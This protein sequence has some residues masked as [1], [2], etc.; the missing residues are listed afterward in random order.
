MFIVVVISTIAVTADVVVMLLP[1]LPLVAVV[2]R[3]MVRRVLL[4]PAIV[5]TRALREWM[6]LLLV[7]MVML[8]LVVVA[9]V[10]MIA[11]AAVIVKVTVVHLPERIRLS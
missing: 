2:K 9:N 6:F 1:F 11:S 8:I 7:M 5:V 4:A 3:V 10:G